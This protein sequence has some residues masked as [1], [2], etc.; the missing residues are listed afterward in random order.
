MMEL[1]EKQGFLVR[2]SYQATSNRWRKIFPDL[3]SAERF[4]AECILPHEVGPET[5]AAVAMKLARGELIVLAPSLS[6]PLDGRWIPMP[7]RGQAREPP[8]TAAAFAAEPE[9]SWLELVLVGP[10]DRPIAGAKAEIDLPDG[11]RIKVTTDRNG[12]IRIPEIDAGDCSL[13]L[14]K[15]DA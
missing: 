9:K 7:P 4:L 15:L 13:R 2:T 3:G 11:K 10:N 6:A 1:L 12:R 5:R 8:L 14:L